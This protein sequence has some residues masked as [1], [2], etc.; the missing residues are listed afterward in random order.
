MS[1]E[2]LKLVLT[3]SNVEIVDL[4]EAL[5]KIDFKEFM[6]MKSYWLSNLHPEW[7]I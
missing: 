3:S 7:L 5:D 4:I 2:Y 1:D 6:Q